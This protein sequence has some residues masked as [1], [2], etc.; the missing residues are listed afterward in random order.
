MGATPIRKKRTSTHERHGTRAPR[1]RASPSVGL[2]IRCAKVVATYSYE[3]YPQTGGI[4]SILG[5]RCDVCR[6]IP[7]NKS[8]R[9]P[10]KTQFGRVIYKEIVDANGPEG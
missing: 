7:G 2:Y 3:K 10:R 1:R 9:N 8:W 6:R 4:R 5:W